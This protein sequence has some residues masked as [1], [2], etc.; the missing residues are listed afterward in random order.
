M[1]NFI[2]TCKINFEQLNSVCDNYIDWN[3]KVNIIYS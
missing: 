1:N 3:D 2:V